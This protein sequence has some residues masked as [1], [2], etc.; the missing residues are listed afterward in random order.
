[1]VL[2]QG[3]AIADDGTLTIPEGA[4]LRMRVPTELVPMCPVCG[5]PMSMNLRADDTFVEDI[6]WHAAAQSYSEF[7]SAHRDRKVLFL[8]TAVGWNMPGIIKFNF[9][10][11]TNEWPGATYACLN[12]SE[13][14][15]PDEIE[16]KSI[17]IG[18][19]IGDI[20]EKLKE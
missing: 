4:D 20:L 19:D 3:F 8:E 15:A 17:C 6:G 14:Y 16:A 11:M 12:Y 13:A 2:A 18:G 1:M 9:W 10:K 5:E 7:L